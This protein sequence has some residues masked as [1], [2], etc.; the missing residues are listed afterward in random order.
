MILVIIFGVIWA[1]SFFGGLVVYIIDKINGD[2]LG[3]DRAETLKRFD[4]IANTM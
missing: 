2:L 3:E 4:E 1:V